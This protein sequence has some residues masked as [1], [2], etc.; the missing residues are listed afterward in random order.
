[1]SLEVSLTGSG[2]AWSASLPLL[3]T[4]PPVEASGQSPAAALDALRRAAL[5]QV[6][7]EA[8]AQGV[9][10]TP[11]G[12]VNVEARVRAACV[13]ALFRQQH[14][15]P[16]LRVSDPDGLGLDVSTFPDLDPLFRPIRGQRAVAEAVARRWLTPLGGLVYAPDYGA[17]LASYL[18]AGVSG[19][20]LRALEAALV[21]QALADERVQAAT[22]VL[23]V[24]GSAPAVSLRA[25]ATLTTA[26]G[27]FALVLTVDQLA[28]NLEVLRA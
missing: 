10:L 7:A 20:R 18:N 17:G 21:T 9:A 12:L 3:S 13:V 14:P 23:A 25:S 26:L 24:I 28:A 2:L 22:V 1:M 15:A 4:A 5:R 11:A 27:P 6:A 8:L 19:P 16:T